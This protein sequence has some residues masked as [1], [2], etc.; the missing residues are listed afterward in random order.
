[1]TTTLFLTALMLISSI[2]YSAQK[3]SCSALIDGLDMK[4]VFIYKDTD[5]EGFCIYK[6]IDAEGN[7]R[8]A[9]GIQ[10][11]DSGSGVYHAFKSIRPENWKR[12][13]SAE[14]TRIMN[15][16]ADIDDEKD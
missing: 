11:I 15:R 8:L 9:V 12:K 13:L 3:V 14:I 7:I 1:M 4:A 6:G 5:K 10:I 16:G 2:A